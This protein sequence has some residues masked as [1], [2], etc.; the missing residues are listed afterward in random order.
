MF[1]FPNPEYYDSAIILYIEEGNGEQG[2]G[3]EK[4]S[5]WKRKRER[6]KEGKEGRREGEKEGVKEVGKKKLGKRQ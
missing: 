5:K 4:K 6:E 2:G 1:P 3:W